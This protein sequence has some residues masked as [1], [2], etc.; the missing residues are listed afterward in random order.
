MG[1]YLKNSKIPQKKIICDNGKIKIYVSSGE[2]VEL[3]LNSDAHPLYRHNPVYRVTPNECD[4]LVNVTE[5]AGKNSDTDEL[6]ECGDKTIENRKTKIYEAALAGGYLDENI[7]QI[8]VGRGRRS[9]IFK[10]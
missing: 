1:L 10:F 5:K 8:Y 3:F 2:R 6:K 4:V 9:H 7:P